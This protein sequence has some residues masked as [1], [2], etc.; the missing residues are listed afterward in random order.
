MGLAYVIALVTDPSLRALPRLALFTALML[1][2][3]SLHWFT[4]YLGKHRRLIVSYFVIQCALLFAIGLLTDLQELIIGLY[5]ALAGEAAGVL[6]PD[7]RA[8][9]LVALSCLA[10]LALNIA[11]ISGI[12]AF[13]EMGPIVVLMF[14]FTLIYV[15][16]YMR[17]TQAREQAQ[18]LLDEL[19]IAHHRLQEYADQVE[20]LTISRERERMARELHDTLAQGLAGLILQLEAADSYLESANPARAQAVVRQAMQRARITL[21]EA[22]RAI[23]ALRP[24]A[25]EEGNL[26]DALGQAVDQF[27]ATTGIH[28]A[29]EVEVGSL[30]MAPEAAQD[31]LRIVQESLNNVARHASASCVRVRLSE[32]RGGLQLVIQDDGIGFDPTEALKRPGCFGL[33]GMQERALRAGGVLRLESEPGKGAKVMLE[34]GGGRE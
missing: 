23:Q 30:D 34:I 24:P 5:M 13:I 10:V 7:R 17:Q 26:V 25:L 21:D 22:R 9:I 16:M 19:E 20:E 31:M 29:F 33:A 32:E 8:V 28:A 27:A 1:V 11:V 6:W 3:G 14:L 12:E 4:P 18:A 15:I 2:S